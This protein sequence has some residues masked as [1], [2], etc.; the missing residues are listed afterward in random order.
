MAAFA[1]CIVFLFAWQPICVYM[2]WIKPD[3]LPIKPVPVSESATS[4]P[5]QTPAT[6]AAV[7]QTPA[8]AKFSS[9]EL[10]S[11]PV[12]LANK[13]LLLIIEPSAGY[14]SRIVLNDIFKADRVTPVTF[15]NGFVPGS[16]SVSDGNPWEVLAAES[17]KVGD[18]CTVSRTLRLAGGQVFSMTQQWELKPGYQIL[19]R[20]KFH[21]P[22]TKPLSFP[23]LR[24]MTS[25][26]KPLK[27]MTGDD[28]RSESFNVDYFTDKFRYIDAT[29]MD[30]EDFF[31]KISSPVSWIGVDNKYFAFLML[32]SRPFPCGMLPLRVPQPT[33][34]GKVEYFNA[35]CAGLVDGLSIMP[36]E[37]MEFDFKC[38]AGP[39]HLNELAAFHPPAQQVLHLSMFA[40]M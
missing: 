32:P 6:P 36:G 14:V 15:D 40:P 31:I 1:V 38:F 3:A 37:S 2:G 17:E 11:A 5:A 24:F 39:K 4:T 7:P 30:D 19:Y 9:P 34:A 16:F 21:N 23:Q 29:D 12:E 27:Y 22:D 25:T 35:A 28:T 33:P 8:D 20:V 10:K 26:M 13:Q 18:V